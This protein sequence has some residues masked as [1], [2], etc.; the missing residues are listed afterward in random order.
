MQPR[1]RQKVDPSPSRK[2]PVS[3]A[4]ANPS[5]LS[6]SMSVKAVTVIRRRGHLCVNETSPTSG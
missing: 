2:L 5:A 6:D 3:L 4:R 1:Q